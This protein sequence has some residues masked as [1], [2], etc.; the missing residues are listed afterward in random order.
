MKIKK[1]I[2]ISGFVL[3]LFSFFIDDKI[4]F[5]VD[6]ISNKY[7]DYFMGSI[8]HFGSVVII[9]LIMTTLFMINERKREWIPILWLSFIVSTLIGVSLKLIVARGRPFDSV[10][11]GFFGLMNYSFPSLH[12][13]AAFTGVE[14]LN[15][16]FPK[17]KWFWIVSAAV[18]AL[19]RVYLKVHYLSDVVFGALVGYFIGVIFVNLEKRLKLFRKNG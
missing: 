9:F 1:I 13:T 6:L 2:L 10:V 8:T 16:E 15:K 12:A 3:F 19:S 18:V 17:L 11:L 5:F 14:V 7:L 4:F